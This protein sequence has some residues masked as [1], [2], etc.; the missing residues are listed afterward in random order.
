MIARGMRFTAGTLLWALFALPPG[1]G[2]QAA[3]F[4]A[5]GNRPTR[6]GDSLLDR[7]IS[8]DFNAALLPDAV[9]EIA[10]NANA[11]ISYSRELLGDRRV[12]LHQRSITVGA[13]L[14]EVLGDS[15]LD[16]T[17]TDGDLIVLAPRIPAYS[18]ALSGVVMDA[19]TGAPLESASLLFGGKVAGVT[20]YAG[21]FTG[22]RPPP[23]TGLIL[24]RK[25]GYVAR[26]VQVGEDSTVNG[27]V[28]IALQPAPLPLDRVVVMGAL[29]GSIEQSLPSAMTVLSGATL[30]N[31]QLGTIDD[32][33]RGMIPGVMG[34]D[35]GP[36]SLTSHLG[37]VRGAASFSINY[38]KTY[39]DGVEVAA[40]FLGSMV[41]P[42]TISRIE[43]IRGP[44]GAALHGSD[45]SSGVIQIV[46]KDGRGAVTGRPHFALSAAEGRMKSRFV[47]SPA[48]TRD[49]SGSIG[50]ANEKASFLLGGTRQT[51]GEYVEGTSVSQRSAYGKVHAATATASVDLQLQQS[52]VDGGSAVNPIL[53]EIGIPLQRALTNPVRVAR[54]RTAGATLRLAPFS[55]VNV[56]AT[57][58]YDRSSLEGVGSPV[59]YISA[60]DSMLLAA[61]GASARKS[62][63]LATDITPGTLGIVGSSFSFG[64][65]ASR[66]RHDRDAV[67]SEGRVISPAGVEFESGH[68]IFTQIN[69][70]LARV[71]FLTAGLRGE[72]NTS[73]GNAY[74]VARLP[75]LGA[76]IV[77]DLGPLTLKTRASY[78]KGIRPPPINADQLIQLADLTQRANPELAPESQSG[79]E[80]GFDAYFGD[81]GSLK[82][83]RYEQLAEG[84]IQQVMVDAA[85]HP[86]VVQQQN[87][88]T[89]R[90]AGWEAEGN[91]SL[92]WISLLANYARTDSRVQ[93]IAPRYTGTLRPGDRMLEVPDWTASATAIA[94]GSE[95]SMSLGFWRVGSWTNYDWIA[96]YTAVLKQD[97]NRGP[98][99]SYWIRYPGFT[100]I[101]ASARERL[102]GVVEIFV[103]GDNLTNVQNAGRDNLHVNTGRTLMLGLSAR[104]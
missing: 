15:D 20:D 35:D 54:H 81:R 97:P 71:V 104:Y 23:G 8:V 84:L 76:A 21:R 10:R 38:F 33:F 96:L 86:R 39:V 16:P 98:P 93:S 45:A 31:L 3:A 30:E 102:G 32:L 9:D 55:R 4:S 100:Q 56:L 101:R 66:L 68:G 75:L 80:L 74:G 37:S 78:G 67:Q 73:F 29:N 47:T 12:S 90:N 25:I 89:I 94:G 85:S 70:S 44:Q 1:A 59:H 6:N 83:T 24:V 57:A 103:R 40:P 51:T 48:P 92:G 34:W 13:A 43:V 46:T 49:L 28:H 7:V 36:S 91:G 53:L 63:R 14:A 61:R 79:V 27:V 82:L 64:Y 58:G 77:G 11:R 42:S 72:W 62:L 17:V 88:G 99:R 69:A 26:A 22:L 2:A 52:E 95:R 50:G 87:I 5:S 60:S 65:D 19:A 18:A 41:D